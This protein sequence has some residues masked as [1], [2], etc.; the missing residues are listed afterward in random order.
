MRRS[1]V[2]SQAL[3]RGTT[4]IQ[5]GL[6]ADRQKLPFEQHALTADSEVD[7]IESAEPARTQVRP[8][9]REP[10]DSKA[11]DSVSGLDLGSERA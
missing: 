8:P 3:A 1:R 11:V 6:S 5:T 4:S 2:C 9:G 10:D 7:R